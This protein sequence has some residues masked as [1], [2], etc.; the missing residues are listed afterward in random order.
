MEKVARILS[1]KAVIAQKK[2]GLIVKT[3]EQ[4]ERAIDELVGTI[5]D[6]SDIVY[7]EVVEK[8]FDEPDEYWRVTF[9][10][11]FNIKDFYVDSEIY[12]R[13][14]AVIYLS[15]NFYAAVDEI[16]E[17]LFGKYPEWNNTRTIFTFSGRL[18]K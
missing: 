5:S 14:H 17:K 2:V 9:Q 1:D 13:G 16:G 12:E 7:L 18:K 4:V 6:H 3:K 11:K 8:T 15:D 10:V